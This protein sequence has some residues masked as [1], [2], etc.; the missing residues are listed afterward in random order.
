MSLEKK[1]FWSK[2]LESILFYNDEDDIK[3]MRQCAL[4]DLYLVSD[5]V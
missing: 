3:S 1:F 5:A 4:Y 2:N